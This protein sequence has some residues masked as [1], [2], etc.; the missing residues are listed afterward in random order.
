MWGAEGFSKLHGHMKDS[1]IRLVENSTGV[2]LG[3]LIECLILPIIMLDP[4]LGPSLTDK[5]Q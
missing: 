4:S 3:Q 2:H 5:V 1:W